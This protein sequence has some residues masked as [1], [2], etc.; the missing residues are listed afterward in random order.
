MLKNARGVTLTELMVATALLSVG[1]VGFFGA[2]QFITKSI[3][4]SRARTL[5]TNLAQEKVESLKN[6]TYYQLLISTASAIDNNFTPGLV[7]DNANY[8]PETIEI[9]GMRFVR[10][11]HVS[12]AQI[13]NN[14][15]STVTYTFPDTGMKQIT[16]HVTWRA[17]GQSKKYSLSNLLENPNINPLDCSFSGIIS[18]AVTGVPV[19]GALVRVQENPDWNS[20]TDAAGYYTFRV[21]HGTYTLR[22]SSAGWYDTVSPAQSPAA[23][24]N[25]TVNMNMQR[26]SSGSLV[27]QAWMNTDL[28]ISQVTGSSNTYRGS[29]DAQDVEYIELFNPTTAAINIAGAS[30]QIR[31]NYYNEAP[32]QNCSDACFGFTYVSSFVPPYHYYLIASASHFLNSGAWYTADAY[33]SGNRIASNQAGA[34]ELVRPDSSR[35]VD[36]VGWADDNDTAPY[37]EGSGIPDSAAYDGSVAQGIQIVRVSSPAAS[38]QATLDFGR[39]YDSG[40]NRDDFLYANDTF[41]LP[42]FYPPKSTAHGPHTVVSGKPAIGALVATSD[43]LSGSTR[44]YAM[45]VASGALSL[46]YAYFAL[47]GVTTGT[48]VVEVA[49]GSYYKELSNAV[50]GHSGQVIGIPNAAT[51][52]TYASIDGGVKLDSHTTNGFITGRITGVFNNPLSGIQVQGGGALRTTGTNGSFFMSTTS[53]PVTI[54]ANPGNANPSYVEQMAQITVETGQVTSQDF[55]LSQG[56]AL[57][58]FVTTGTTPLSNFVVTANIGSSQWGQ[59]TTDGTGMF[60]IK[61]L[62]TG[63]YTVYPIV[64]AGQDTNPNTLSGTVSNTA[65]V[66]VGT[67]TVRGAW[68]FIRGSVTYNDAPHT[69]GA[70][71]LA[72]TAA[73]SATPPS[74]AGST[75]PALTPL[76]AGSSRADGTY[77]L[78]VRGSTSTGGNAT[79]VLSAY[80]PVVSNA[81]AVTITTKTYTGITVSPN[82]P[83]IRDIS[84][85]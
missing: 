66:T 57:R 26:V 71:I 1:I 19:A 65:T 30:K 24:S 25:V 82:T 35:I 47:P 20:I 46:Q 23:G 59:A 17:D 68:G 55:I 21:Y 81:G 77:E 15:I 10:Y 78:Q 9:A 11:T 80:V 45:S 70:L 63:T 43:P 37:F 56:G 75:A 41:A 8:G 6:L 85:P 44:A 62:S 50:V 3:S 83:T 38:F 73:I 64:E 18:S 22:V 34:V 27:G 67:F 13:D 84:I 48:W 61:N 52:P 5:A 33:Y 74:I 39:A 29:G 76:Y 32:G 12:L 69:S 60:T 53:G 40:D 7:Y 72:S 58:G 14:V 51:N 4:V 28:V 54:I 2:F 42:F 16:V 49:S 79:Y 36:L 31:V